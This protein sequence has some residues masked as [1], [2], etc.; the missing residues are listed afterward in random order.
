MVMTG[1]LLVALKKKIIIIVN[2]SN[3]NGVYTHRSRNSPN[4][5]AKLATR[6][7][8]VNFFIGLYR[9]IKQINKHGHNACKLLLIQP[10]FATAMRSAN[11]QQILIVTGSVQSNQVGVPRRQSFQGQVSA[12]ARSVDS[13]KNLVDF[14]P[15]YQVIKNRFIM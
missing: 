11:A 15:D 8:P 1:R 7:L 14:A 2:K 10:Y 5:L 3:K 4:L 12:V 6:S 9:P 13:G